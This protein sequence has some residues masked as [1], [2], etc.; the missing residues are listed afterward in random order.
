MPHSIP[1]THSNEQKIIQDG[2]RN[3]PS[4]LFAKGGTNIYIYPENLRAKAM[5]WL[6]PLRDVAIIGTGFILSVL[7][8]AQSGFLPPLV[9]TFLFAFL[10]IRVEDASILDFLR[11]AVNFLFLKQQYYE[12]GKRLNKK[13]K[14]ELRQR[15]TA[16]QLMGISQLTGYGVRTAEGELAFFLIKPDNLSVLSEEGVRGRVTALTHLLC[17]MPELRIL[18]LDSRESFQRNQEWYRQRLEQ[19]ELPALRELLRQDSAHLDEIQTT[20]ASAREFVLVFRLDQQSG[21]SDEVQLR[22][23]EKRIRDQGFHVRLAEEQDIK[24]L[25]AVYYQQ[26]VTTD[27]FEDYDGERWAREHG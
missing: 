11:Y 4:I 14:Q 27:C 8:L 25:L 24:R 5:L 12:W 19:E 23:M 9:A 20:T 21:E 6:W 15:Q 3:L 18:A 1:T 2:R 22:Q 13:Q 26:D 17:A 16:R 10:S 7:A